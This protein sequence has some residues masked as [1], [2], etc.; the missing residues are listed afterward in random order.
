MGGGTHSL[1]PHRQS[2]WAAF[3][4]VF[5]TA[6]PLYSHPTDMHTEPKQCCSKN[7]KMFYT[8]FCIYNLTTFYSYLLHSKR[9]INIQL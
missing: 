5:L 3:S 4:E 2:S 9:Y 7:N 8:H 6:F 1:T